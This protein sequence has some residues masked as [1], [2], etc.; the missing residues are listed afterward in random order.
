LYTSKKSRSGDIRAPLKFWVNTNLIDF[1]SSEPVFIVNTEAVLYDCIM[2]VLSHD[3]KNAPEQLVTNYTL[4]EAK[5]SNL[6]ILLAEDNPINRK[7]AL[8][9]LACFGF[10]ADA[11]LNG[12]EAASGLF[13]RVELLEKSGIAI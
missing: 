9:L 13:L 4:S 5:R 12:K 7:L 6:R 1:D 2:T 3:R 10:K 8:H 11:V